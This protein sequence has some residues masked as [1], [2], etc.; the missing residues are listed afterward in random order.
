VSES[1]EPVVEGRVVVGVDGSEQSKLALRWGARMC[2]ATGSHLEAVIAWDYPI[3]YGL[4]GVSVQYDPEA[5]MTK[6]LTDTVEEVFGADRPQG[7]V[8][9]VREGHPAK[10]LHDASAGATMLVVG[11]R[12]HGGFYGMLLGSVSAYVAEHAACPVL[13]VREPAN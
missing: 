1:S 6:L 11:T 4:A 2:A 12:G 3:S 10:V 7:M 9:S 13:V 5:E 8:L